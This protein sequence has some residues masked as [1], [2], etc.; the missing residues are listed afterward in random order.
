MIIIRQTYG[1]SSYRV[2]KIVATGKNLKDACENWEAS[3]TD[4]DD[5]Y[6]AFKKSKYYANVDRRDE[7]T[8]DIDEINEYFRFIDSLTGEQMFDI[9]RD[10][11][12]TTYEEELEND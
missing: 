9:M 6:K 1:N 10:G 3:R 12:Y 7:E 5:L 11:N 2:N 4:N 8:A